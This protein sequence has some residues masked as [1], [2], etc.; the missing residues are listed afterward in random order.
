MGSTN[1]F[2]LPPEMKKATEAVAFAFLF[3][4]WRLIYFQSSKSRNIKWQI[5]AP[6]CRFGNYVGRGE[7]G[8][9]GRQQISP[10]RGSAAAV[11]MTRV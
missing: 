3:S 10:P 1:R 5:L 4:G 2:P 7:L 9:A 11:E 6:F 8:G